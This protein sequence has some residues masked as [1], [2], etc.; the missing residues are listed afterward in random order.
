MIAVGGVGRGQELGGLSGAEV[1]VVRL[2]PQ[3]RGIE[4]EA[5]RSQA[6]LVAPGPFARRQHGRAGR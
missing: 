4:P 3:Q 6:G 1:G 2:G 5:G